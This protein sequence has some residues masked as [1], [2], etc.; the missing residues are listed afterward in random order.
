MVHE[1]IVC[2]YIATFSLQL[3]YFCRKKCPLQFQHLGA[4]Y[5]ETRMEKVCSSKVFEK[6][7]YLTIS[8]LF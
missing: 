3:H 5:K 8:F 6:P 2:V 1:S 7:L 4:Q